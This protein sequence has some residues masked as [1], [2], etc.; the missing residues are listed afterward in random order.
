MKMIAAFSLAMFTV[1]AFSGCE[2]N[3]TGGGSGGSGTVYGQEPMSQ[4]DA[5]V[6]LQDGFGANVRSAY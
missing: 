6:K 5:A 3:D 4:V 1:T 2:S